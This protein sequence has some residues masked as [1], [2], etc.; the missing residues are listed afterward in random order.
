MAIELFET[1]RTKYS[2][3]AV[4]LSAGMRRFTLNVDAMNTLRALNKGQEVTHVT[5]HV[6][7]DDKS[8]FYIKPCDKDDRGARKLIETSRSS[9]GFDGKALTERLGWEPEKSITIK[10]VD[11]KKLGW[12][13]VSMKAQA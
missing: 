12:I 9:V 11:D 5:L 6:D 7:S 2:F 13:I 10:V 8:L 4:S 1:T 3:P